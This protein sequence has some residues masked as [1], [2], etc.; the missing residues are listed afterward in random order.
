MF[1]IAEPKDNYE[2]SH[3]Q[4]R[5]QCFLSKSAKNVIYNFLSFWIMPVFFIILRFKPSRKIQ[6]CD[7]VYL[8]NGINKS[9]IP[10]SL[11]AE[12]PNIIQVYFA[13]DSCIDRHAA[14]FLF[15]VFLK[16][17]SSFFMNL[18]TLCK[19]AMY[20]SAINS[21]SPKAIITYTEMSFCSSILT[22]YCHSCGIEHINIMHGEKTSTIRESFFSFDRFYVWHEHYINLFSKQRVKKDQFIVEQPNAVNMDL[23]NIKVP[24][25]DRYDYTFYLDNETKARLIELRKVVLELKKAHLRVILRPHPRGL[26]NNLIRHYFSEDMIE[27][28]ANITIEYSIAKTKYVVGRFSTVLYQ[29]YNNNKSVVIDDI[30]DVDFFKTLAES[31]YIMLNLQ[32]ELLSSVLNKLKKYEERA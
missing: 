23:H 32:H 9:I 21:Y 5:C 13:D 19:I 25:R 4:Y 16:T 14:F 8:E 22:E 15:H 30:T 31:N 1:K 2:R 6:T 27:S 20:C 10:E 29:A 3:A 18:K 24:I 12:F 11:K 17:P 28:P 7:A 26:N